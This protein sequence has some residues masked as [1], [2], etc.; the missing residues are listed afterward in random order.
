MGSEHNSCLTSMMKSTY[1][2]LRYM[3]FLFFISLVFSYIEQSGIKLN[4]NLPHG[5]SSDDLDVF[6]IIKSGINGERISFWKGRLDTK[7]WAV[8]IVQ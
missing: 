4:G 6:L 5:A 2:K 3:S 1:E 7:T 8:G